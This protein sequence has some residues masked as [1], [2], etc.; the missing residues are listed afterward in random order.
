M[1]C[2][3]KDC[4]ST[5]E[6]NCCWTEDTGCP[7]SDKAETALN[8]LTEL[9]DLIRDKVRLPERYRQFVTLR[10]D[11]VFMKLKMIINLISI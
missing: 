2:P 11:E 4:E 6:S 8:I 5:I 1:C 9:P 7:E 3:C 10:I